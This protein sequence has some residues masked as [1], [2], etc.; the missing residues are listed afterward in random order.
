[1]REW[2]AQ[3]YLSALTYEAMHCQVG[4]AEADA[5]IREDRASISLQDVLGLLFQSQMVEERGDAEASG[6]TDKL[7]QELDVCLRDPSVVEE[8]HDF[9]A[10]LWEPVE[11]DWEP[12]LRGVYH[13]TLA[14]ALLRSVT[15][16]CPGIDQEDLSV[17]LER[18][19]APDGQAA[20]LGPDVVEV[21]FN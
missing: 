8:L 15:D 1:M 4:L 20:G 9:G 6:N 3:I 10:T 19:P 21:W 5:R 14:A 7:R 17:D 13:S 11:A 2:L 16:L 12:W 18:G